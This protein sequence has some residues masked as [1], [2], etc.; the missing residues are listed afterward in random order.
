MRVRFGTSL[1]LV[2][3]LMLALAAPAAAGGGSWMHTMHLV[4]D[5]DGVFDTRAQGQAVFTVAR[6]GEL[7]L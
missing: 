1:A 4:G 7:V 3:A 6:D 5:L 2:G